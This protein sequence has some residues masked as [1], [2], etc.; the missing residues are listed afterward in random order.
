MASLL[1]LAFL[2][3]TVFC[4]EQKADLELL[5]DRDSQLENNE[6]E[7]AQ[8]IYCDSGH[9][10]YQTRWDAALTLRDRARHLQAREKENS[11]TGLMTN[12]VFE[13]INNQASE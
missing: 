3:I 4:L 6:F 13:D 5:C 1:N 12:F 11:W 10:T 2:L 7:L 9:R 8:A